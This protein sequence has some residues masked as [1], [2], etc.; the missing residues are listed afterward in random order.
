MQVSDQTIF[1]KID[2]PLK[3]ARESMVGKML[4]TDEFGNS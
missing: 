2:A 4:T 1:R 3:K